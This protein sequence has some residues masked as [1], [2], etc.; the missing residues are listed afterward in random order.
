VALNATVFSFDIQ[1]NDSDRGVYASLSFRIAQHPS[2][3]P[4][5][6][7]TRVLAHC[8]EYAEGIA[9]S[10]G[11]LSDPDEP[12]LAVRDLSGALASWIEVGLPEPARLHK[13]AKASPRVAVYPH[14]DPTAWLTRVR[15]E[16][17]RRAEKIEIYAIDHELI[18]ALAARLSRRMRFECVRA[19]QHLYLSFD[20]GTI[21]GSIARIH[22]TDAT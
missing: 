2:E 11:G 19:E 1:L 8:L 3:T 12:A 7:V 9:F 21:D 5:Y 16:E 20:E 6:L 10:K 15:T 13:A 4:E 17:I 18:A 22:I 14:R